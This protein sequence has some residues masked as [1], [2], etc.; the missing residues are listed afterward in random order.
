MKEQVSSVVLGILSL[1]ML[2]LLGY[3]F[4]GRVDY[5]YDLEWMEGGM[6]FGEKFRHPH[7]KAKVFDACHLG[8]GGLRLRGFEV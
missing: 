2:G 6:I 8:S 3:T 4:W 5:P 1:L 7:C